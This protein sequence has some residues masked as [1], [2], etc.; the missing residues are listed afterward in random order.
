M[1]NLIVSQALGRIAPSPTIAVSQRARDLKAAGA[2]VIALAAGEPDFPTPPHVAEAAIAAIRD[3]RTGYTA[4][5][6][7]PEL[8]E[9]VAEKFARDNGLQYEPDTEITVTSGGKFLIYA[10]M[11]ASLNPG[12]EV[13]I[14]APYWVSYPD[15]V[16]LCDGVPVV[17]Q[18]SEE[19][20]FRL[21]AEALEG[22]ITERT[23]W[24]MLNSPSNPTGAVLGH[25]DLR[26]LAD[27]LLRHPKVWVL[28][29]DIYEHVIYDAGFATIA[30]VEPELKSR[31]LTMNGASKAYAMTGWRIGFGGGPQPLIA[32]IRKLLGQTTSNPCSISQWATVEALRGDQ[33][34]LS[35]R[36]AAFRQR[37]DRV[38]EALAEAPG[39]SC[40]KPE[41]A[42]YLYPSVAGL[43]GRSAGGRVLES[44]LDVAEVLLEEE[45]V[46][47]VP[48]T[49]F[50]KA[51]FMRLS[52]AASMGELEEASARIL[53]FCERVAE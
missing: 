15:I 6:G 23:R 24:V 28:T 9:A 25:D 41:G 33:G 53:R 12:D 20:G 49:A 30:S 48:G 36:A 40:A 34:F 16:K 47:L 14:P 19:N 38:L 27:V 2:D 52:Y 45:N 7:I 32:T 31:T 8:K 29:D 46:A 43:I 22:A 18:T 4:V 13:V 10:A 1:A 44:D 51:P 5:D 21:T 11:M 26:A 35:E 3:G 37:R 17:V 39:L 42:F 50:G